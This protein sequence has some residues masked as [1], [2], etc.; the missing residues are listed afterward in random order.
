MTED[1]DKDDGFVLTPTD[2]LRFLEERRRGMV[3]PQNSVLRQ[4]AQPVPVKEIR[5]AKYS[6]IIDRLY[7]AANSQ[8][9][10]EPGKE[11]RRTLVGL[12]AP[13]IGEPCRIVLIDTKVNEDRRRYGRLECFINP[14]FVWRSHETEEGREG[15]FST[16]PVWG[17]VRRPAAVKISGYNRQ[18]KKIERVLEGFNARI[19]CHEIDHL[20][21]VRFPERITC[22]SKRHLVHT[23]E[24][25]EYPEKIHCWPRTCTLERWET[26]KCE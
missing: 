16:G 11:K 4:T 18:G 14:V 10:E 26:Y 9:R 2:K 3:E 22:D 25:Q 17:L 8:R 13:Q 15:C 7:A 23:E 6:S 21:G 1:T 12:A 24:L 19:A 5:S 20:D